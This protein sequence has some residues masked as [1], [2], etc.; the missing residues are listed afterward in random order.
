MCT[1]KA[2]REYF[3][4]GALPEDGARCEP[5]ILPFDLPG[6]ESLIFGAGDKELAAASRELSLQATWALGTGQ[7]AL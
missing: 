3:Q 6:H 1:A 5:E 4:N 7:Q 2:V